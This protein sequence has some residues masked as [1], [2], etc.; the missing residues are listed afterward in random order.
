M[1]ER[2]QYAAEYRKQQEDNESSQSSLPATTEQA[3]WSPAAPHGVQPTAL[4]TST[5]IWTSPEAAAPT[6][7]Q[8]ETPGSSSAS[9]VMSEAFGCLNHLG[10][11]PMPMSND[12]QQ[13]SGSMASG[14][15]S[16][17]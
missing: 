13:C 12:Q 2:I 15:L 10:G 11:S 6:Y 3:E 4:A 5:Q 8:I 9:A 14:T 1:K 16:L 17:Q 7:T